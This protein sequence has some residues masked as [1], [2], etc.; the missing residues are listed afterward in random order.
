MD[1]PAKMASSSPSGTPDS[2][3]NASLAQVSDPSNTATMAPETL[4]VE[5]Q[6][7]SEEAIERFAEIV[8]DDNASHQLASRN[9]TDFGTRSINR[10]A[11]MGKTYL[12][13]YVLS[14]FN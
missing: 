4:V 3:G 2:D 11:R 5:L 13:L 8:Q 10:A 9:Q 1:Q 6:L 7:H 14:F 12:V